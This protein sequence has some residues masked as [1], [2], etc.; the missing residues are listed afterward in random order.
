MK[1]SGMGALFAGYMDASTLYDDENLVCGMTQALYDH[2]EGSEHIAV[3]ND[4]VAL[5]GVPVYLMPG[6]GYK[7][8]FG[9]RY[10]IKPKLEEDE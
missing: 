9:R 7:F 5:F 2:I 10:E 3:N 6:D 1:P 8:A 4:E